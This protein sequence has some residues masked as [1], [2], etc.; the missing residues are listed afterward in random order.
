MTTAATP[1]SC[2]SPLGQHEHVLEGMEAGADDYLTKPVSPF[3]VQTRLIAAQQ[4]VTD[5][6]AGHAHSRRART[7]T[8]SSLCR[9]APTRS[10]GS[11]TGCVST[12]TS[13][14]T[15]GRAV[16]YGHPYCVALCDLDEFKRFNDTYGHLEGDD[17]L[18][19]RRPDPALEL[20]WGRRRLPLRRRGVRS[21]PDRDD[22]DAGRACDG[23]DPPA[24]VEELAI[25]HEGKLPAGV[26]T[27]SVGIAA[28]D[29]ASGAAPHELLAR[30]DLALYES[31][32]NG[33]NRVTAAGLVAVETL[34]RRL[35]PVF[36]ERVA[37]TIRESSC[38][39]GLSV[40][41]CVARST[42]TSPKRVR[43]PY[44]HS[45]LSSSDQWN[46]PRTSMPSAIARR[47]SLERLAQVAGALPVVVGS[48]PV[49]GHVDGD[50]GDVGGVADRDLGCARPPLVAHREHLDAGFG[51]EYPRCADHVRE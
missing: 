21:R 50:A 44:A 27:V 46:Q 3:D 35:I 42:A 6:H 41:A 49:L 33:R 45:K 5:L 7:P 12:R 38:A 51:S 40:R 37:R 9:R 48:D 2:S 29:A 10:P 26:M 18:A 14:P 1:T 16:R 31:K 24:A 34:R 22:D 11:A 19:A 13:R 20:A 47:D 25:V 30:A 28:W 4:L 15:T 8:S 43:Y 32:A 23:A 39:L 36:R 17:A